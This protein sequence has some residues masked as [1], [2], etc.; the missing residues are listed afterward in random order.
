MSPSAILS[1]IHTVSFETMLN[2]NGGNNGHELKKTLRAKRPEH[3]ETFFEH[4]VLDH[5]NPKS[6]SVNTKANASIKN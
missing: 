1:V 3:Q 2:F 4:P 6:R 5:T